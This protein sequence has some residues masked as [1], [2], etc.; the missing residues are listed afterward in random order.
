L[1]DILA[2][3]PRLPDVRTA[4]FTDSDPKNLKRLAGNAALSGAKAYADYREML[5][6]EQLDV[7]AVTN[8]NGNRAAAVIACAERKLHVI[9]EKPLAL[10]LEDLA[11]VRRAA[12]TNQIRMSMLFSMRC[13]PRY[14]A[15]RALVAS[16]EIGEVAQIASQKS[17]RTASWP[18]WRSNRKT[19][20]GTMPWIGIHMVD[21]M[22]WITGREFTQAAGFETQIGFRHLGEV[23]NATAT[24]F[25]LD[26]SGVALLRMDYLRPAAAPTHGDDRLRV[27]GTKGVVEYQESTGLTLVTGEK[28]PQVVG[29]LPPERSLFVEF[30]DFV[31]DGKPPTVTLDDI[32]RNTEIVIKAQQAAR[33]GILVR[34]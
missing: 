4:A 19:Y 27:A 18:E 21:L 33:E 16:G 29:S 11:R 1:G 5:A 10:T 26:N 31:Y 9:A 7:V 17:Y 22:R 30:L 12:E 14:Q 34:L 8:D 28:K 32:Y 2:H 24:I 25:R 15:M 20:G 13:S 3:L 6:R 23:E